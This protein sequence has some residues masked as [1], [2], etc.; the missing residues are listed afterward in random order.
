MGVNV[1]L[2]EEE[3]NLINV[4]LD[5]IIMDCSGEQNEKDQP[6]IDKINEKIER[7]I[8]RKEENKAFNSMIKKSK[9]EWQG[10]QS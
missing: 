1:Y 3:I 9:K 5:L 7:A 8:N 10:R 4:G 6:I 2:T